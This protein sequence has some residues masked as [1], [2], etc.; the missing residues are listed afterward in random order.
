MIPIKAFKR[1]VFVSRMTLLSAINQAHSSKGDARSCS[2]NKSVNCDSDNPKV[3]A[4]FRAE[5]RP[6]SKATLNLSTNIFENSLGSAVSSG[7]FIRASPT[8]AS[9]SMRPK[10]FRRHPKASLVTCSLVATLAKC[11]ISDASLGSKKFSS[12]DRGINS[13]LAKLF[14]S[15]STRLTFARSSRLAPA[16]APGTSPYSHQTIMPVRTN[17]LHSAEV[18]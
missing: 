17:W 13:A 12:E 5:R 11:C 7:L 16:L 4:A 18:R 1:I 8:R 9:S 15:C 14:A 6:I 2:W 3:L 10:F